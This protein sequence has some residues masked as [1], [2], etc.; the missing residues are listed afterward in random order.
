MSAVPCGG[1]HSLEA[2]AQAACAMQGSE[3]LQCL[4]RSGDASGLY[5]HSLTLT[6]PSYGETNETDSLSIACVM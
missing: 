6:V 5:V 3:E 1:L 4:K 2:S